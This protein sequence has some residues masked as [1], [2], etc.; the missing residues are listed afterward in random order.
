MQLTPEVLQL[1][2]FWYHFVF[3]DAKLNHV[4]SCTVL[5][6]TLRPIIG[7]P[8]ESNETVGSEKRASFMI[9]AYDVSECCVVV[10]LTLNIFSY[11]IQ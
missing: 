2:R 4:T 7:E 1:G 8:E 6:T 9:S 10:F 3:F 5:P 11:G